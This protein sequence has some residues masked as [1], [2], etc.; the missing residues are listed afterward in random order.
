MHSSIEGPPTVTIAPCS[1]AAATF[2][3]GASVGTKTSQA[4]PRARAAAATPWAWLPAEAQTTPAAQPASPS[5]ASFA[6]APRTLKDPVR[7]RFS[8]LRTT[9]PPAR[10]EKVRDERTGVRRAIVSTTGRAATMS[11]LVTVGFALVAMR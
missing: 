2:A 1:R 10:S 4:T 6:A 9:S 8:A 5:A 7:W 3:S 11:S